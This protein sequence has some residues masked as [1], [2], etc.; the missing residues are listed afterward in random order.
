VTTRLFDS[1]SRRPVG[2][3]CAAQSAGEEATIVIAR[4]LGDNFRV[5]IYNEGAVDLK[6]AKFKIGALHR[7][8]L[9]HAASCIAT[10]TSPECPLRV[11]PSDGVVGQD[12]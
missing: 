10:R 7:T 4:I 11:R 8:Q 2:I 1:H 12:G 3:P 9:N 5:Y 6:I